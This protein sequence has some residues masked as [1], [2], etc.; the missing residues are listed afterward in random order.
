M[1]KVM[2]HYKPQVYNFTQCAAK[3]QGQLID[4]YTVRTHDVLT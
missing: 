4:K 2:S 3:L 1:T